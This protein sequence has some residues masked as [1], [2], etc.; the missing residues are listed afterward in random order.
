LRLH[1][2]IDQ[3]VLPNP[4]IPDAF[5]A[6]AYD[7][8][9]NSAPTGEYAYV[10]LKLQNFTTNYKLNYSIHPRDKQTVADRLANAAKNLLYGENFRANGPAVSFAFLYSAFN[11]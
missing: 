10:N 7:L 8:T 6:T 2:T 4:L 11:F 9:D 1:Q 5:F 3:G